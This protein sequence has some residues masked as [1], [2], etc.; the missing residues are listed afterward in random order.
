MA[1]RLGL[2]RL[3][4]GLLHGLLRAIEGRGNIHTA[5]HEGGREGVLPDGV[6]HHRSVAQPVNGGQLKKDALQETAVKQ[7]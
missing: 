3:L 6:L 1:A 2:H 4:H 7:S 5:R